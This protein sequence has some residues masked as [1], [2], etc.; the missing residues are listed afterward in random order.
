MDAVLGRQVKRVAWSVARLKE[1]LAQDP[2][3]ATKK[4]RVA[5][6]EGLGVAWPREQT[7]NARRGIK[8]MDVES[9]AR[10]NLK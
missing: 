5:F 4:Y 8:T 10:Q 9:W 1:E 7:F 6:A 2:D 3:N